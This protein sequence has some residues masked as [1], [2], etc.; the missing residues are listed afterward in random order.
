MLYS[1]YVIPHF[2][3]HLLPVARKKDEEER[4]GISPLSAHLIGY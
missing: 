1:E 4:G 3:H 2:K